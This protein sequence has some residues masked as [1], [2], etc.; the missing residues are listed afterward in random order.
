MSEKI[1]VLGAGFLGVNAALDLVNAGKQVTIIDE[2]LKHQYIPGTVD[3]IRNRFQREELEINLEEFLPEQIELK[4]ATVKDVRPDEK[5]VETR[6]GLIGYDKLVTGLGGAPENFGIDISPAEHAWG[7]KPAQKLSKKAENAEKAVIVGA[8]YVGIE[9]AGELTEKEVETTLVEA[10]T[11]PMS[12]L[13]QKSSEKMLEILHNKDIKFKGGKQVSEVAEGSVTFT[14]GGEEAADLIVWAAG[15][16]ASETV[17]QI[18]STGRK[19]IEVNQGLSAIGYNDIF[20]GGD[21]VD[22]SGQKTAHKAMKQGEVIAE[23][24]VSNSEPLNQVES[25]QNFLIVSIGDKAGLIFQNKLVF[26]ANFLRHFKDLVKTY[27][28]TRLKIKKKLFNAD[29]LP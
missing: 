4:E 26:S 10:N 28:F 20:A 27:Y 2:T 23:N 11:R 25:E 16:K 12:Y 6:N 29:F 17:K 22:V 19:G 15:V 21:C 8:G 3:I 14:D 18:F 24:I 7:I 9:V 1:V 5:T 13:D